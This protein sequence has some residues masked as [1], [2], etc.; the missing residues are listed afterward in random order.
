MNARDLFR[1]AFVHGSSVD[2]NGAMTLAEAVDTTL[3]HATALRRIESDYVTPAGEERALDITVSPV[4]TANS[5]ILGAT[6]LIN[7]L[8]E[9]ARIRRTQQLSGEMSGEMAL[10]LRNSLLT[11]S[12]HAK[13]LAATRDAT[14]QQQLAL[15]I[16][17]EAQHLDR[18][19]GGFLAA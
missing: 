5:E 7:D 16:A 3:Q 14:T 6:C 18:T 12:A 8:T 17:E 9:I 13:K 1:S 11:I 2:A 15:E 10:E 4:H 19:I